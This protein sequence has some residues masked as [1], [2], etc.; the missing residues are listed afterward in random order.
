[1]R[2]SR[3]PGLF[4]SEYGYV[5]HDGRE[6]THLLIYWA[7]F[8]CL[9]ETFVVYRTPRQMLRNKPETYPGWRVCHKST[10]YRVLGDLMYEGRLL[11]SAY[12]TIREAAEAA[13]WSLRKVGAP[14][15]IAAVT[16]AKRERSA[17]SV[18]HV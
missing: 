5:R 9:G 18:I 4:T 14:K 11:R 15:L 10:G 12:P 8:L 2:I 6:R 13:E 1:M 7:S 16:K 17:R 3:L